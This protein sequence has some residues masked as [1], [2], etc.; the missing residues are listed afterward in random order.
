M[1]TPIHPTQIWSA[2]PPGTPPVASSRFASLRWTL[3]LA[4]GIVLVAAACSSD[5]GTE[6]DKAFAACKLSVDVT[7]TNRAD[8]EE[9]TDPNPPYRECDWAEV[10][11][12]RAT[13][14]AGPDPY[15]RDPSE[16]V[17]EPAGGIRLRVANTADEPKELLLGT[18]LVVRGGH[19]VPKGDA[20]DEF[21]FKKTDKFNAVYK[22]D[23]LCDPRVEV[24]S[25]GVASAFVCYRG[26]LDDVKVLEITLTDW[27]VRPLRRE[28]VVRYFR[29]PQE[30]ED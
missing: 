17:G 6:P 12:L 10:G 4:L 20:P 30:I 16:I 9:V 14:V 15:D 13:V 8:D 26:D 1:L 23:T 27:K 5:A 28:R 22:F 24:P 7:D 3:L 21:G 11:S 18:D 19:S 25:K 2:T 29:W